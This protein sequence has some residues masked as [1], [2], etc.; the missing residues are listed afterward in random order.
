MLWL[1]KTVAQPKKGT[2]GE[3]KGSS[4][5]SAIPRKLNLRAEPSSEPSDHPFFFLN[6][7][8][9]FRGR[10]T[11]PENTT[12]IFPFSSSED[13]DEFRGARVAVNAMDD[14]EGEL[15]LREVFAKALILGILQK[16][17]IYTHRVFQPTSTKESLEEWQ[18]ALYAVKHVLLFL[19]HP[20]P[21]S[22]L[23]IS[24]PSPSFCTSTIQHSIQKVLGSIPSWVPFFFVPPP[25]PGFLYSVRKLI[26]SQSL[27]TRFPCM[28]MAMSTNYYHQIIILPNKTLH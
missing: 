22:S 23:P 24:F 8:I 18:G 25:P 3:S 10:T 9:G 20:L 14:G 26:I 17:R 2:R 12:A 28:Y 27:H 13:T 7:A 21:S 15:S 11:S 4:H 1:Q 16:K 6:W 5:G 19:S